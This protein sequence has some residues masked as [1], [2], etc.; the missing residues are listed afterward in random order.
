MSSVWLRKLNLESKDDCQGDDDG[1][2]DSKDSIRLQEGATAHI[3]S[4]GYQKPPNGYHCPVGFAHVLEVIQ[5]ASNMAMAIV[6]A[7]V[8]IATS[9]DLV[10]FFD[11]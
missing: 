8:V 1:H 3:P 9:V 7:Q 11:V 4:T 6:T 2:D 10:C 5:S